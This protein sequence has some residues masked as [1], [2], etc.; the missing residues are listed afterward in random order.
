MKLVYR[1]VQI[2]IYDLSTVPVFLIIPTL[3][4]KATIMDYRH[5][6]LYHKYVYNKTN[7]CCRWYDK[8]KIIN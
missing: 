8:S 2:K 5:K 3:N 6:S 4:D 1:F 7:I